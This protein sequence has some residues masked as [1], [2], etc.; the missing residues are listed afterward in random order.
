MKKTKIIILI[1]FMLSAVMT[2]ISMRPSEKNIV[3]VVQ[4]G[5][6][7]YTFDLLTAENQT[8][9]IPSPDGNSSNTVT[10]SDGKI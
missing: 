8:I 10:I 2:V 9:K 5:K 1:I 4:D 7:I 3:E 6:I